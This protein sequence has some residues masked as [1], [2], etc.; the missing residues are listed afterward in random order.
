MLQLRR[1]SWAGIELRSGD[2]RVLI[3]PL[4]N[5]APLR[6]FLGKPHD[7]IL[8]IESDGQTHALVTHRHPDHFDPV[9]LKRVVGPSGTA[10]C[11]RAIAA[12]IEENGLS[13]QGMDAW[14]RTDE[15]GIAVTAVPAVD[16]RGDEQL[17]WVIEADGHRIIH[18]GDTIWH[19]QWWRIAR[20]FGPFDW[21]FLPINGVIA[22]YPGL[23][24]SGLPAT[25]TPKQA[26]VAARILHAAA[27]CP[28]HYGTF[29]NPPAYAEQDDVIGAVTMSAAEEGVK[30]KLVTPGEML[31]LAA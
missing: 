31:P 23:E 15:N 30:L 29:N 6:S 7:P 12:E 5:V 20:E 24:P 2:V 28:I 8:H 10:F 3:D 26:C 11:P 16:W 4:E 25:L 19:G 14:E 22:I 1:L 13:A 18:C 27:L 21:A 17:S 9:T